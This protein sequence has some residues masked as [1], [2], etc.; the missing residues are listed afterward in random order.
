MKFFLCG[1][2]SSS[3]S[4]HPHRLSLHFSEANPLSQ[5]Q[6]LQ[7]DNWEI[8]NWKPTCNRRNSMLA[9][10]TETSFWS[11][12]KYKLE[13]IAYTSITTKPGTVDQ[14]KFTR[15]SII[16]FTPSHAAIRSDISCF[17]FRN[18]RITPFC[19]NRSLGN[20]QKNCVFLLFGGIT[21]HHLPYFLGIKV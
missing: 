20:S 12:N 18:R 13:L 17:E 11:T 2:I 15:F 14:L 7:M 9:D 5:P 19:R 21:S 16:T 1:M 3:R 6:L 10:K 8:R 4:S